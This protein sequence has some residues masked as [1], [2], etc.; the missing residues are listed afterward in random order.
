MNIDKTT[1]LNYLNI[2]MDSKKEYLDKLKK[3]A[4]AE[5]QEKD[6]M[7]LTLE[8]H[9]FSMEEYYFDGEEGDLH[10]CC[11]LSSDNGGSYL[12]LNVP[13]SDEVLVDI[14][15]YATKKFNKLKTVLETLK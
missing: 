13:L 10:L 3:Q 12:S 14:L 4:I 6:Q 5:D 7:S 15:M 1:K 8:G 2:V 9:S 11:D